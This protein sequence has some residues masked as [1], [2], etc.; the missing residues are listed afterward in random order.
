[1]GAQR[2]VRVLASPSDLAREVGVEESEVLDVLARLRRL[3][4]VAHLDADS[5]LV[6]DLPR[7]D[8]F[9]RFLA[10][11]HWGRGEAAADSFAPIHGEGKD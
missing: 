9:A 1:V 4:I 7:L 5:I 8:N 10:D 2:S 3:S 11:R 6:A